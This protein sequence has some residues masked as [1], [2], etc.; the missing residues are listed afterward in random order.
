MPQV[1]STLETVTASIFAPIFFAFSGLRVDIGLLSDVTA[2]SWTLGLIVLAI[3][4]KVVGTLIGGRIAGLGTRECLALGSGLAALGAM[5]IVVAIVGLNLGV[6]SETGY[7][8][9]VLVAIVTSMVAPMLLK[10]VVRGWS[11][12]DEERRRLEREELLAASEILSSN[13][14]LLPTRGGRNSRYAARLLAS[15]LDDPEITVLSVEVVGS[16]WRRM[17]GSIGGSA[18]APSEVLAELE[19]V[20]HRVV[21]RAAADPAEAIA[22]EARLGY[23]MVLMGA[24]GEERDGPGGLF[25][26]VVD[27]VL[28]RIDIPTVTVRIPSE[29]MSELPPPERVLVPVVA[30]RVSRAA[31]ELAYSIVRATDGRAFALHV[32][33]RPEGQ[34][35][36][37]EEP[38]V[39]NAIRTG[40][41]MVTAAAGFGERLGVTVETGVRVAPHVEEEVVAVANTGD[42]DLVV[43]GASNRPMSDRPF[44]GHRVRFMI[45]NA[46]IPV[47]IV[48]LP[49][50]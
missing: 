37:L 34:G 1:Q 7:T 46:T 9:A 43:I 4:A 27:R 17:F 20:R 48:T 35:L 47:V 15:V 6:L 13:R 30:S 3:V 31:E 33:N 29:A 19:E 23:D 38:T 8:V 41:E 36:M 44:F 50:R 25:S 12:P 16:R 24:S 10:W 14:V 11:V 28:A 40:Q 26:N 42:F 18:G 21:T 5:G 2:I 45:D 39:T 49:S 22:A 32:V